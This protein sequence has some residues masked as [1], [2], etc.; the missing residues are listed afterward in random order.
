MVRKVENGIETNVGLFARETN[1]GAGA[2]SIDKYEGSSLTGRLVSEQ[3]IADG[4]ITYKE[5]DSSGNQTKSY[6]INPWGIIYSDNSTGKMV[7]FFID[8]DTGELL[9][10]A[11]R[12]GL[13]GDVYI[14]GVL[15]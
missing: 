15:Q 9:V 11:D 10:Q 7:G 8:T 6:E 5:Y 1:V 12:I 13:A 4:N 14:N 3:F 2:I